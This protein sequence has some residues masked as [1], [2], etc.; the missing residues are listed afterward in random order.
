[1]LALAR[2]GSQLVHTW[3]DVLDRVEQPPATRPP[4]VPDSHVQP[5]VVLE[6]ATAQDQVAQ[7]ASAPVSAPSLVSDEPCPQDFRL[8]A[9]VFDARNHQ[10]SLAAVH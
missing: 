2:V 7:T 5:G 9:S 6:R 10:S 3:Q 1:M 8:L 4:L